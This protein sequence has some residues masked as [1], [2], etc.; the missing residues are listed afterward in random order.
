VARP[1]YPRVIIRTAF[2][3]FFNTYRTY[4][5]VRELGSTFLNRG[6]TDYDVIP[7]RECGLREVTVH[8][9]RAAAN[10][11]QIRVE[12]DDG[13]EQYL[14]VGRFFPEGYYETED[15]SG[16]R[17]CVRNVVVIGDTAYDSG[18]DGSYGDQAEV[19]LIGRW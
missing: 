19:E 16:Y 9:R 18:N 15:L 7:V 10:I 14:D 4:G 8:V 17:R 1:S 5:N 13:S 3:I 11:D 2:D 6:S 12:F